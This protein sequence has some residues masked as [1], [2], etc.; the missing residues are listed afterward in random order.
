[1]DQNACCSKACNC[2]SSPWDLQSAGA[3]QQQKVF[4][5]LLGIGS[6]IINYSQYILTVYISWQK[7]KQSFVCLCAQF[8]CL[9]QG[10]VSNSPIPALFL[11]KKRSSDV[12]SCNALCVPRQMAGRG[13]GCA[14]FSKSAVSS[15][16]PRPSEQ[17][18]GRS[19]SLAHSGTCMGILAA[20]QL[21]Q[22]WCHSAQLC[23]QQPPEAAGWSRNACCKV[24]PK[25]NHSCG[26]VHQKEVKVLSRLVMYLLVVWGT[27]SYEKETRMYRMLNQ[28]VMQLRGN[29][30]SY[31]L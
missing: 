23:H 8:P 12:Q 6:K 19:V 18:G 15:S 31:W 22:H 4:L 2:A 11:C 14:C 1:M 28:F 7:N 30:A 24:S 13:W 21:S 3:A 5:N 29:L 26:S 9:P 10:C 17:R 16:V 20:P 25:F 27:K